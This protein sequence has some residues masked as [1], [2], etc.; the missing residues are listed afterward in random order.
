V[1]DNPYE[2]PKTHASDDDLPSGSDFDSLSQRISA[3]RRARNQW[4]KKCSMIGASLVVGSCALPVFINYLGL[5][6]TWLNRTFGFSVFVSFIIGIMIIC[7]G[8]ISWYWF[9]WKK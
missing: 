3:Y 1:N 7:V 5:N 2:P 9:H 8:P 4:A 6:E